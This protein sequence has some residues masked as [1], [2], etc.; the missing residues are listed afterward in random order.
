MLCFVPFYPFL[1]SLMELTHKPLKVVK[2]KLLLGCG[3][4]SGIDAA[5]HA[6]RVVDVKAAVRRALR[7]QMQCRAK[8]WTRLGRSL[9]EAA[10]YLCV[11]A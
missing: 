1:K 9:R 7:P 4:G 11:G 5:T 8:C 6:V 10:T 3:T 2:L